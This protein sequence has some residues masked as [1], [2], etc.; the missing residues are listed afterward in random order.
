MITKKQQLFLLELLVHKTIIRKDMMKKNIFSNDNDFYIQ[1]KQLHGF[2][3][4]QFRHLSKN[5]EYFLTPNGY[6]FANIMACQ[7]NTDEKYRKVAKEISW[8]PFLR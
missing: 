8:L 3:Y 6:A 4:I 7:P 5:V 1:I 2:G